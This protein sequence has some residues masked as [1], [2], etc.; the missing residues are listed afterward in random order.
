[1]LGFSAIS[2]LPLSTTPTVV[3]GDTLV[4]A[5]LLSATGNISVSG[6][7]VSDNASAISASGSIASNA[8]IE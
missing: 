8:T 2:E 4:G 7:I 6:A 5:S 1:M 3:S